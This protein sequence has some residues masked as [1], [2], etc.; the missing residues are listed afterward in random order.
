MIASA[1]LSNDQQK[2]SYAL[3]YQLGSALHKQKQSVDVKSFESGFEAGVTGAKPQLSEKEQKAALMLM[4]K[5]AMK[6]FEKK[7]K[8][9]SAKNLQAAKRFLAENKSKPGVK[10]LSNG[11]QYKVLTAGTGPQPKI[12]GTV[13]V[14]YQG[15]LIDGKVFDSS[16]KRGKPVTFNLKAVI[17]AWQQ[18]LPMMKQGAVWM[19]Y[20]PPKLAYGEQGVPGLIGPNSALIFKVQLLKA[21]K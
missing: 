21:S 12:G 6:S 4:Q 1:A 10:T 3:G 18:I 5:Q 9:E 15:Q 16:F 11:L 19:V 14:N 7:F 2:G 20:V 17:K 13:T 8:K